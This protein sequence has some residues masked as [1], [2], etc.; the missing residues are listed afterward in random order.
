MLIITIIIIIIIIALKLIIVII[1]IIIIIEIK[2][3]DE[4]NIIIHNDKP[5]KEHNKIISKI[6]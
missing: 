4:K 6:V 1:T 3:Y 2:L 5:N